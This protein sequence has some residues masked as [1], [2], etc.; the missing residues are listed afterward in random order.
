MD[1]ETLAAGVRDVLVTQAVLLVAFCTSI[2]LF[3]V[4]LLVVGGSGPP[5]LEPVQRQVLTA[6]AVVLALGAFVARRWLLSAARLR[7]LASSLPPIE[8][9]AAATRGDADPERL[10]ALRAAPPGV[11]A[12]RGLMLRAQPTLIGLMALNES[13]ALLGF[14]LAFLL[15]D[16]LRYLPFAALALVL[17]L[18]LVPRLPVWLE[19]ARIALPG[20]P[21]PR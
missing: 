1:R 13:V 15:G 16:P 10:A 12:L 21:W 7:A 6:I 18:A 19:R 11:V 17:Q 9:L 5:S 20:H 2:V 8:E 14:V 3:G 4:V